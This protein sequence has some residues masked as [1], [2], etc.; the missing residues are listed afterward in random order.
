[1]KKNKN[2]IWVNDKNE[3]ITW[4]NPYEG[5]IIG[6]YLQFI[7]DFSNWPRYQMLEFKDG[8]ILYVSF[9]GY[10]DSDNDL[11]SDDPNYEEC[12]EFY[13]K[14]LKIK[15]KSKDCKWKMN[16]NIFF[17]YHNFPIKWERLNENE[18]KKLKVS[19]K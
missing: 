6:P 10:G 7:G 2:G 11:D 15:N 16:Q 4:W 9:D 1:M 14:I 5:D 18:I 13:F 19:N 8:T 12:Y 17:S 3:P